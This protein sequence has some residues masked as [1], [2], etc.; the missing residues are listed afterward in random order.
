MFRARVCA[1]SS[2]YNT[3]APEEEDDEEAFL[4]NFDDRDEIFTTVVNALW[5]G[6][7]NVRYN[8]YY[9]NEDGYT[10]S[11]EV[12]FCNSSRLAE[13]G[14]DDHDWFVILD[15]CELSIKPD[16]WP[17]ACAGRW[18]YTGSELQSIGDLRRALHS[19]RWEWEPAQL[20]NEEWEVLEEARKRMEYELIVRNSGGWW[21]AS[22]WNSEEWWGADEWGSNDDAYEGTADEWSSHDDP[23]AH[24]NAEPDVEVRL[25]NGHALTLSEA[26]ELSR[27]HGGDP[28]LTTCLWMNSPRLEP[29]Y[30]SSDSEDDDS[31]DDESEDDY[32]GSSWTGQSWHEGW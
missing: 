11:L 8:H 15:D 18:I 26:H 10:G 32:E 6:V 31:E 13:W 5:A 29:A 20:T 27:L 21:G 12:R 19:D 22:D 3:A 23:Y 24:E 2:V 4:D 30:A 28:W 16:H 17:E 14:C 25:L 9:Y 1:W 7:Y